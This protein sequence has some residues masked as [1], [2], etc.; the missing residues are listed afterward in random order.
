MIFTGAILVSSVGMIRFGRE[1]MWDL[2]RITCFGGSYGALV[3][4]GPQQHDFSLNLGWLLLIVGAVGFAG[5]VN[6][7][8]IAIKTNRAVVGGVLLGGAIYWLAIPLLWLFADRYD[9]LLL[10]AACLPLALAPLPHRAVGLIFSILMTAVLAF[11]SVGGLLSYHRTMQM[12]VTETGAM[13]RQGIPRSQIDAGYSL[14]GRDLY[15]YPEHGTETQG[16]EPRIPLVIGSPVLP[17]VV[18]TS[19]MPHTV[20][21]RHFSGCGP[22]GLGG[23]PLFILR[24]VA[25]PVAPPS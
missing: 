19:P 20:I 15:V 21:W 7:S 22:L 23:R 5:I 12:I 2:E 1:P 14:N 25:P 10:P 9:L 24:T 8:C 17:Y 4:S 3:L 16:N 13:V 11:I 6:A 18:S